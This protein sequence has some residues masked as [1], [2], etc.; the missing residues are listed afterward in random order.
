MKNFKFENICWPLKLC[1]RDFA[2]QSLDCSIILRGK[3]RSLRDFAGKERRLCEFAGQS[4]HCSMILQGKDMD[5]RAKI[6]QQIR[7]SHFLKKYFYMRQLFQRSIALWWPRFRK[8]INC[9]TVPLKICFVNRLN[10]KDENF[11]FSKPVYCA[12]HSFPSRLVQIP[13]CPRHSWQTN[14]E[15]NQSNSFL[16]W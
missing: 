9:R 6:Q 15:Q 2:E 1:L 5:F 11:L 14:Y 16:A 8:I 10:L 13:V 4:L 7:F 12:Y 3:E